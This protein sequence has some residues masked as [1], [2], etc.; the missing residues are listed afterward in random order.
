MPPGTAIPVGNDRFNCRTQDGTLL[1]NSGNPEF[2]TGLGNKIGSYNSGIFA[3]M[4]FR[5]H[6]VLKSERQIVMSG[7]GWADQGINVRLVDW[8]LMDKNRKLF[9]LHERP[10]EFLGRFTPLTFRREALLQKGQLI[11]IRKWLC[12]TKIE[13]LTGAGLILDN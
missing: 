9:L 11:E 1:D 2:L 6:E 8:L 10:E 12:N 5:F 3:E 7:Y 13:D 4:M